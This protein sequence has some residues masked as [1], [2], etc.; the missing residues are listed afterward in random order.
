MATFALQQQSW[1]VATKACLQNQKYYLAP[2][3]KK[4]ANPRCKCFLHR[5]DDR[6]IKLVLVQQ[7]LIEHKL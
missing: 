7:L 3:Q 2:L 4:F 5:P 1:V 6:L